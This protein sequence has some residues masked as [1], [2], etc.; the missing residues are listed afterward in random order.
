MTELCTVPCTIKLVC[1]RLQLDTY[2]GLV[3]VTDELYSVHGLVSLYFHGYMTTGM[4]CCNVHHL[5]TC[6]AIAIVAT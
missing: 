2:T 6:I 1:C 5:A 4:H 3:S